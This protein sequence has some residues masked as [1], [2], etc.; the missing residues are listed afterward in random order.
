MDV[1]NWRIAIG[2]DDFAFIAFSVLV[3]N[4]FRNVCDENLRGHL[5][6]FSQGAIIE[7]FECF[8]ISAY[9]QAG[10]QKVM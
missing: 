2:D 10:S 7:S 6:P 1:T 3:E 9:D 4:R 5:G 8:L